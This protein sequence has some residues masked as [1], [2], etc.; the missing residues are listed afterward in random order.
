MRVLMHLLAILAVMGFAWW[1]YGENYRTRAV[2]EEVA[3]L[4]NRIAG[5]REEIAQLRAE[6]AFLNRPDRLRALVDL[7]FPF[8]GLVSPR[9]DAFAPPSAIPFREEGPD[10]RPGRPE[11]PVFVSGPGRP[12][13]IGRGSLPPR[14]LPQDDIADRQGEKG[15]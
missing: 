2:R 11:E 12:L 6:W 15:R 4:E 13:L 3:R 14:N 1:A 8:L 9:A 10:R 7:N 5:T